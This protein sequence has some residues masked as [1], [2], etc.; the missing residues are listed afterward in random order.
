MI[1][2]I[3][4]IKLNKTEKGA[5]WLLKIVDENDIEFGMFGSAEKDDC[6]NFRNQ[7]YGIMRVLNNWNLFNLGNQDLSFPIYVKSTPTYIESVA[8]SQGEYFSVDREANLSSGT[9]TDL[10]DYKLA[11]IK[12][13]E[14]TSGCIAARIEEDYTI[15]YFQIPSAYKGFTPVYEYTAWKEEDELDGA[16]NFLYT[17]CNIMQICKIDE[18]LPSEYLSINFPVINFTLDSNNQV[19]AIGNISQDFWLNDTEDGYLFSNEEKS[20]NCTTKK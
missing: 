12:S 3:S 11:T 7:T 16:E 17:I 13:L 4:S 6:I 14:S 5:Y 1:G 9:K 19:K 10:S 2:R 18:L 8:N 20:F 15:Q